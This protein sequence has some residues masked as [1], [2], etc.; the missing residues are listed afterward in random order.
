MFQ[1]YKEKSVIVGLHKHLQGKVVQD[2]NI[3]VEFTWSK[4][5][6]KFPEQS[7]NL[8]FDGQMLNIIV[9]IQMKK[10]LV[11][12]WTVISKTVGNGIPTP[13]NHLTETTATKNL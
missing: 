1:V 11:G 13:A 10:L 2:E 12:V 8:L 9:S 3:L 6:S 4:T 7:W 5:R